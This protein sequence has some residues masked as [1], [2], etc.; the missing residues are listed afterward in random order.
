MKYVV[1]GLN[2][3]GARGHRFECKKLSSGLRAGPDGRITVEDFFKH[4]CVRDMCD[5]VM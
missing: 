5:C 4:L 2:Q 3:A 1:K